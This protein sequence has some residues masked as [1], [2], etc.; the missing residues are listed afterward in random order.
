MTVVSKITFCPVV[1]LVFDSFSCV[2]RIGSTLVVAVDVASS[3]STSLVVLSAVA[4]LCSV[5]LAS[6]SATTTILTDRPGSSVPSVQVIDWSRWQVASGASI[7]TTL[8]AIDAVSV[9]WTS[10]AASGPS[11]VTVTVYVSFWPG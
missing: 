10:V 11:L 1:A 4:V 2:S 7:D 3:G 8:S 9:R 5:P 6:A